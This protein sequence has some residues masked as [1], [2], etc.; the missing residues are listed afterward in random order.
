MIVE[1]IAKFAAWFVI[2]LTLIKC[3]TVIK[4]GRKHEK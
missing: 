3:L 4:L 1:V 2:F